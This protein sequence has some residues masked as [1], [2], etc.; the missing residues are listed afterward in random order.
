MP[1]RLHMQG[2]EM[3]SGAHFDEY[4]VEYEA[5]IPGRP[6]PSVFEKPELCKGVEP[7][8]APAG[9]RTAS[10][11]RMAAVVPTVAYRGG[12]AEVSKQGEGVQSV[13]HGAGASGVGGEDE[14]AVRVVT[15]AA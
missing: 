11:M 4:V 9:G 12:H 5:Y 7:Q 15:A 13:L 10:Q 6:D 2:N 1:L 8:A 3:F 14:R